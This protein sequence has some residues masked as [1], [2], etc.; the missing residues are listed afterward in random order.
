M[1]QTMSVERNASGSGIIRISLGEEQLYV[2]P[3]VHM[4]LK[5]VLPQDETAIAVLMM[6]MRRYIEEGLECYPLAEGLQDAYALIDRLPCPQSQ[7]SLYSNCQYS[8]FNRI[9]AV[10]PLIMNEILCSISCNRPMISSQPEI[11]SKRRS[12]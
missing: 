12:L 6:G 9:I 8:F 11:R 5:Q 3:F 4:G 2:N 1:E 10:A 7:D